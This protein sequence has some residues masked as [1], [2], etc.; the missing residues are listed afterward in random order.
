MG[1]IGLWIGLA[2][3]FVVMGLIGSVAVLTSK[4]SNIVR[5]IRE[6]MVHV[7]GDDPG[8]EEEVGEGDVSGGDE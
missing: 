6:N 8:V 3:G 2:L 1:L 4:W 5:H 7:D